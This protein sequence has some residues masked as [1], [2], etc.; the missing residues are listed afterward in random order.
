MR[1]VEEAIGRQVLH[2]GDLATSLIEQQGVDEAR[3]TETLGVHFGLPPMIGKL[4]PPWPEALASLPADIAQR[5]TVMPL[6]RHGNSLVIA[7]SEP[8]ATALEED[9]SFSLGVRF[10]Q[11]LAPTVRIRQALAEHL[12]VPL[13]RRLTRLLTRLDGAPPTVA[14][15]PPQRNSAPLIAT[16]R[17]SAPP[18]EPSVPPAPAVAPAPAVNTPSTPPPTRPSAPGPVVVPAPRASAPSAPP[19]APSVPP[20]P[21]IAPAPSAPPPPVI[22]T[23]AVAA[24]RPSVPPALPPGITRIAE[25]ER[26][27]LPRRTRKRGPFPMSA[28]EDEVNQAT[29]SDAVLETW[30]AFAA[31]FFE[32]TTL[33]TV[34]G[35][36]A[37]ARDASGPGA[38]R[39]Y[40]PAI[41]ISLNEPSI[42]AKARDRAV[43]VVLHL[44]DDALDDGIATV[45]GRPTSREVR[46]SLAVVPMVLRGRVVGL[47][48]GDEGATDANL[49][50]LADVITLS[51][52]GAAALERIVL[53]KKRGVPVEP[54][55]PR[56]DAKT[57]AQTRGT[58]GGGPAPQAAREALT[59]AV[60]AP[61]LRSLADRIGAYEM[62]A[63]TGPKAAREPAPAPSPRGF[64]GGSPWIPPPGEAEY[65]PYDEVT[66]VAPSTPMVGFEDEETMV[67]APDSDLLRRVEQEGAAIRRGS[68][69]PPPAAAGPDAKPTLIVVAGAELAS[70]LAEVV[71]G[72]PGA[73]EA[74]EELVSRGEQA[75]P[76]VM[77]SFPGP[78]RARRTA[79][80]HD[81]PPAPV[82]GPILAVL[83]RLGRAGLP[84]VTV[85]SAAADPD[86]RFWATH[87]LGE[88]A[89]TEAANALLP[90]LFDEDVQVRHVARRSAASLVSRG[91][92]GRPI[93]TV[94][95]DIARATDEP[96]VRR[97]LAV[98][99]LGELT[100]ESTVP[101][102]L[103]LLRSPVSDI[104]DAARRAL[105]LVTRHDFGRDRDAWY[106]W[107]QTHAAEHR[108]EW[109]IAALIEEQAPLRRAAA[110]DLERLSGRGFDYDDRDPR[111]RERVWSFYQEWWN[112]EGRPSVRGIRRV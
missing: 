46:R 61:K 43:P 5:H 88:L 23:P 56:T 96:I 45:L 59:R 47:L 13:D 75:V 28:A 80:P 65:D 106:D 12:A 105:M 7:V 82:C 97:V 70:L 58:S 53:A 60:S 11:R 42:L 86:T 72:G 81:L 44:G 40:G 76:I 87:L 109:L 26:G 99:A 36:T 84:F 52:L 94:L 67:V 73:E 71:A 68:T 10:D 49:A 21:V 101:T 35:D 15:T 39:V 20:A 74:M 104:A 111:A 90:R 103:A 3:V 48:L 108:A 33:F 55:A 51:R 37:E 34:Q 19:R 85:R 77:A 2:G 112:H 63:D 110:D 50:E 1:T 24:A 14:A 41:S 6:M 79:S 17:A 83:A 102:L 107:W 93:I 98:E 91:E 69:R 89:Y 32:H 64:G 66:V 29:T 18:R 16:A 22:P 54:P 30:L 38:E 57:P 25:K 92:A 100:A 31:Q 62:I 8:L 27:E 4:P 9:L 95:D 78:L